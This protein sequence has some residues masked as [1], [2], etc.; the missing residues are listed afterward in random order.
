MPTHTQI[1]KKEICLYKKLLFQLFNPYLGGTLI[2]L[3]M[4]G[5]K[6][7]FAQKRGASLKDRRNQQNKSVGI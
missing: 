6:K 2:N 4:N 7:F 1:G 5:K 3:Y